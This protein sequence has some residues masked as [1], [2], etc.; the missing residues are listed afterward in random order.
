MIPPINERSSPA[1]QLRAQPSGSPAPWYWATNVPEYATTD[2]KKLMK[3]IARMEAGSTA[4]RDAVDSRARNTRSVN[5]MRALLAMPSA[6]GQTS[7]NTF[8]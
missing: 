7:F 3:R 4:S 6:S 8:Q 5:C 1:R 2:W